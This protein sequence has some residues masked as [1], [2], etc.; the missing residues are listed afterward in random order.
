[1]LQFISSLNKRQVDGPD[2]GSGPSSVHGGLILA[3]V[4]LGSL[5]NTDEL[6]WCMDIQKQIQ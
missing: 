3:G 2:C 1:V 5:I 4:A 6:L